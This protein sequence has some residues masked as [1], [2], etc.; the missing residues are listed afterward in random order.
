MRFLRL[1]L[2]L[3]FL[4]AL[5]GVPT[6]D[7]APA[8]TTKGAAKETP[9]PKIEATGIPEFDA[10]FMKAK[11]IHETLDVEDKHLIEARTEVA[12]ALGVAADQPIKVAFDELKKRA[13]GK[14]KV[15]LKGKMP[16]LEATEAIPENVQ[17][18]VDAVNRLLDAGEHLIDTGV[19]LAPEAK[20]L[21]DACVD[22]PAKLSTMGLDPMKLIESTKKVTN[23]VKAT[24]GTP[25]RIDRLAKT[26]E[27]IFLDAKA[28]FGE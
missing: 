7:A 15:A 9:L 22:F 21:A 26:S 23:N 20:A 2:V 14:L 11:T 27:G 24:G 3:P 4:G 5:G 18:G 16:R 12:I 6:A 17:T 1:L 10:V 8:K 25:V 28:T 19:Q 13:N